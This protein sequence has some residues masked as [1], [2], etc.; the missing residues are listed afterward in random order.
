MEFNNEESS[1][2]IKGSKN[3]DSIINS[4][5]HATINAGK[6]NDVIEFKEGSNRSIYKYLKGD[7]NDT[8]IGFDNFVEGVIEITGAEIKSYAIN[9]KDH[10]IKVGTG[11]IL[12]KDVD[13]DNVRIKV[14][15]KNYRYVNGKSFNDMD[16]NGNNFYTS[17]PVEGT[18]LG[19]Y[20][21]VGGDKVTIQA[22]AGDD[23]IEIDRV[24][25]SRNFSVNGGNGNDTIKNIGSYGTLIGGLGNDEIYANGLGEVIKYNAG[26]GNDIVYGYNEYDTIQ[27]TNTNYTTMVSGQDLVINVDNGKI[28]L[29]DSK[30][31]QLNIISKR[32]KIED[33]DSV[34]LINKDKTKYIATSEIGKIDGTK[35]KKSANITGN[36]NDNLIIGTIKNDTLNGGG[37]NDTL[38]GGKGNNTFVYSSG[39]DVITDYK[40]GK[41]KI[42]LDNVSIKS[43]ELSNGDVQ[44]TTDKGKLTV[45][46][47][48]G[49]KITIKSG[50]VITNQI[51]G[52]GT[53][54]GSNL[55]EEI[56]GSATND[57][58]TGGKGNDTLYGGAG[59]DTFIYSVGD[60][61]DVIADFSEVDTIKLNSKSTK[62]NEKKSKVK[63]N[64]YILAIG[65]NTITVKN[66]ASKSINVV[67]FNGESKTYNNQRAYEEI[68]VDDNIF[69]DELNSIV[70]TNLNKKIEH[71]APNEIDSYSEKF[72]PSSKA[73]LL[74]S[75]NLAGT[76]ASRDLSQASLSM[77]K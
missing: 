71:I 40:S 32:A 24:Y 30:D 53:I 72:L 33:L 16:Y 22:G 23:F 12:L 19:D 20:I 51:Y 76:L 11:S 77:S 6:G 3:N 42:I 15:K 37:G 60:G 7:G 67:D 59:N 31:E 29:K 25:A 8:L 13:N 64:D 65:K 54:T 73:F 48:S 43:Y 21:N 58:I 39:N 63:G 55:K 47:M 52:E 10:L 69:V 50:K 1:K 35:R 14:G 36:A 4:G 2:N 56:K 9:G 38:T 61:N 18:N 41:D 66:G 26:D 49:K 68:F 44:L 34:E 57:T 27:I 17:H 5:H 75:R 46:N 62:I 70:D 28:T 45:K 74:S